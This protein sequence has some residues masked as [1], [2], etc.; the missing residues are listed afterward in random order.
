MISTDKEETLVKL[1]S[2]HLQAEMAAIA[3]LHAARMQK[4]KQGKVEITPVVKKARTIYERPVYKNSTWWTML[5]KG[6]CKIIGHPQSKLFRR[7]FAVPFSMFKNI[8]EEARS[9]VSMKG[10]LNEKLGDF[11]MDCRGIEGVPLELKILGA[12]RMMAKGCSFDAIAELSGMSIS[13][14]QPF[15]HFFLNKFCEVYREAWIKYP[16][17]PEEAA[18]NLEVYRRLGFPGAVGSV[19]CT[20]VLWERCPAQFQSTY[21]GKEKKATVA[22]EVTVN[23]SRRILYIFNGHPGS[24][25]DKTIVKTDTFVQELKDRKILKDVEFQLFKVSQ[26]HL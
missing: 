6:E 25:N 23:H 3:L 4:R 10:I 24:R 13:T 18:D 5:V 1:M 7:R 8:V 22:Y 2:L 21:T 26:H 20:H 15:F 17:T 16:K 14:M 9:W 11:R 19:D 12:L